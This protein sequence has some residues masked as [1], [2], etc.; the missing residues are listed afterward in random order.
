MVTL[1]LL[2]QGPQKM[3]RQLEVEDYVAV[4]RGSQHLKEFNLENLL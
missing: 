2:T 3:E 1:Q 4:V